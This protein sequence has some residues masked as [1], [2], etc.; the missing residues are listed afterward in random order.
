MVD[1]GEAMVLEWDAMYVMRCN[2]T[3]CDELIQVRTAQAPDKLGGPC[4]APLYIVLFRAL[5]LSFAC[6]VVWFQGEVSETEESVSFDVQGREA[7]AGLA[8]RVP[9]GLANANNQQLHSRLRS[10]GIM[11][12]DGSAMHGSAPSAH[13]ELRDWKTGAACAE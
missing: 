12:K 8:V 6:L 1:M 9:C 2:A 4:A 7:K 5:F 11:C 10:L 13:L 3:R